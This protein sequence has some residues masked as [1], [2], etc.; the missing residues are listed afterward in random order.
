[1]LSADGFSPHD[2][3][4]RV[5][6]HSL[7]KVKIPMPAPPIPFAEIAAEIRRVTSV[8]EQLVL[9]AFDAF[10]YRHAVM[11]QTLS[12]CVG[13]RPR[14]AHWMCTT[15]RAFDG[16]SAYDI[17]ADGHEELVWDHLPGA[18]KLPPARKQKARNASLRSTATVR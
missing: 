18:V 6:G 1:M 14:A 3:R 13:S 2:W 11:A 12:D 4:P 17:L 10:E 9:A 5:R 15:D 7:S 16:L 8:R